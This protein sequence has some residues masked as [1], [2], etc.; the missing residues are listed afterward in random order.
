MTAYIWKGSEGIYTK[1][2]TVI[3]LACLTC[4]Y[5]P[6]YLIINM[7]YFCTKNKTDHSEVKY[8]NK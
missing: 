3:I 4:L 8:K 5:F 1:A 2:L 6:I 7:Y